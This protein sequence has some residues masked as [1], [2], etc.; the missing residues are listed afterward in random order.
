MDYQKEREEIAREVARLET[1]HVQE[2]Q[3]VRDSTT[4]TEALFRRKQAAV[5][6]L[7]TSIAKDKREFEATKDE[8][9]IKEKRLQQAQESFRESSQVQEQELKRQ[10]ADGRDVMKQTRV[11]ETAFNEKYAIFES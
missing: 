11:M 6:D 1:Y 10:L 3:K 7:E 4:E 5:E 8:L 2:M 9:R